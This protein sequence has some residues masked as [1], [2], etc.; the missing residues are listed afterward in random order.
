MTDEP[1]TDNPVPARLFGKLPAHGDFVARGVTPSEQASLDTWLTTSLAAAQARFGVG[2]GGDFV[3]RF[4]AALPWQGS[5]PGTIGVIAASQDASGRRY[6]LVLLCAAADDID[7]LIYAAIVD[8]WD[9]DRLAA[10]AGNGA[11]PAASIERWVS[12]DGAA[13]LDGATPIDIVTAMLERVGV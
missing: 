8:R 6:P 10:A 5:G 4:D 11:D 9:A 2:G 12:H 13:S 3:D 7:G 1:V